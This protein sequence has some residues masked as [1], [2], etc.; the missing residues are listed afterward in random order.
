[1]KKELYTSIEIE[2][3]AERVWQILTDFEQFPDWNPFIRRI[4]GEAKSGTK[5]EA[6]LQPPGGQGMTFRP[7]VLKAE[8]NREFRWLGRLFFP[9]LFDGEHFF[10]IEPLSPGRVRFTQGEHFS[11]LLV[12]LLAKSLDTNT[13]RGFELMNEALK[14]R[15]ENITETSS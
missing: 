14:A 13:R 6:Y 11:G 9:G 15:A 8:P 3:P 1:M 12:P 7:T 10:I 2:A 4:K 5:L